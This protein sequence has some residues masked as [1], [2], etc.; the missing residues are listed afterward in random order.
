MLQAALAAQSTALWHGKAHFE[1][2]TLQ[3][4]KPHELSL[5]QGNAKALGVAIVPAGAGIAAAGA[6]VAA[7]GAAMTAGCP[8]AGWAATGWPGACGYCVAGVIAEVS[9]SLAQA[10]T[11][12]SP[13]RATRALRNIDL[14]FRAALDAS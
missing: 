3:R 14:S 12:A 13:A 10:V 7:A 11:N 8:A 6:G 1:N 9:G 5:V 2:C 4:A